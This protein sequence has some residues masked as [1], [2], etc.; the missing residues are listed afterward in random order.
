MATPSEFNK[1][2]GR[3]ATGVSENADKLV[4]KVAMAIDQA[5]V[6]AT[7]VDT[8]RARANWIASLDVASSS[9]TQSTDKGGAQAIAA[10][11]ATINGYDGDTNAEVHI[12]NNLEYIGFLNDGTSAQAPRGFVRT[13]IKAGAS[14]VK[15]AKLLES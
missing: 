3:I 7:P 13:A 4:K 8:G 6:M 9:I 12:T 15:G 5:V 1:R 14:A 10:A 11:R 2:M